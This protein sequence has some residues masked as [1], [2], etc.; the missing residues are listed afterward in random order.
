MKTATMKER[1]FL[2]QGWSFPPTFNAA[3]G[4]VTLVEGIEDINQSLHILL[5][6]SLGERVMQPEYGCNLSDYQFEPLNATMIGFIR[7]LV[8]KAILYYE[9]RIQ[10]KN[11]FVIQSDGQEAIEGRVEITVDYLVRTTNSRYNFV[12][13]FYLKEGVLPGFV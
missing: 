9:P 7:D 2:G 12:Y 1:T 10:L 4:E 13:D 11:V 6:T 3:R 8:T 5:S